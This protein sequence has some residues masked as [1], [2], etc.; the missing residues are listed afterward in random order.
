MFRSKTATAAVVMLVLLLAVPVFFAQAAA[1]QPGS[2]PIG[3]HRHG[4]HG[5]LPAEQSCCSIGHHDV[6][7]IRSM[8]SL[9]MSVVVSAVVSRHS[10]NSVRPAAMASP[11]SSPAMRLILRI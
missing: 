11:A 8:A 4:G 7:H 10:C 9:H 2:Q 6:A 3:C 1:M 5:S